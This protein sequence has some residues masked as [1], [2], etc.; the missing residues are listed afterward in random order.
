[1]V[2]AVLLNA[3]S[4]PELI[5]SVRSSAPN[6]LGWAMFSGHFVNLSLGA[7]TRS[8]LPISV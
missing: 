4:A 8:E 7:C 3:A 2:M 1:M 5:M 6:H